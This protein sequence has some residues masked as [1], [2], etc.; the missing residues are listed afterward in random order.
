MTY[1]YQR[2]HTTSSTPHLTVS[3]PHCLFDEPTTIRAGGLQPGGG[4]TLGC[5]VSDSKGVPFCSLVHYRASDEGTID[6]ALQPAIGGHFSGLQPMGLI[7]NIRPAPSSPHQH[8]R[9]SFKDVTRAPEYQLSLYEGFNAAHMAIGGLELEPLHSVTH[10]R[11]LVGAGVRRLP[12]RSGRLRGVLYLPPGPG[13]HPGVVDMFGSAGGC[14]QHRSAL[15]ASRGVAALSL[16]FFDYEDLPSSLA[17]LDMSYFREA[18][19]YLCDREEVYS[20]NGVGVMGVSKGGDVVLNMALNI[21]QVTAVVP[22]NTCI[23]NVETRFKLENGTVVPALGFTMEA[24]KILNNGVIDVY[25]FL[26]DP[27]EYPKTI[28]PVENLTAAVLCLV[29]QGDR[30]WKSDLFADMILQRVRGTP[31]E[32]LVQV[33]RYP[34]AG[35]LIEPPYVPFCEM[36]YHKV[37][38]RAMLWG[39]EEL[40]HCDAQ[41]DSWNKILAFFKEK[42]GPMPPAK[43]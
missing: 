40:A 9:F 15:L 39:G 1:I 8:Y 38:R 30:N 7:A 21:P 41:V 24:I 16:A 3:P 2:P 22:I 4:Y 37:V 42:L 43:L 18:V 20:E 23:S 26:N 28:L 12:V 25:E 19:E 5:S 35:H 36:S 13:P 32:S 11:A 17:E 14:L 31:A 34:G 33:I 27:R 10:T 29:G 6:T